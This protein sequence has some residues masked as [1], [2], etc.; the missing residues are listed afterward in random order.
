MQ[1]KLVPMEKM[2][3]KQQR[4]AHQ[5]RRADWNGVDP[6]TRIVP[7]RTKYNRKKLPAVRAYED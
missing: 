7:D 5:A 1:K 4:A 2:N 6:V 3:K